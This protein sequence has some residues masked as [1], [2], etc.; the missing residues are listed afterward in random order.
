MQQLFEAI[1]GLLTHPDF[2]L[3]KSRKHQSDWTQSSS[4]WQKKITKTQII[5][6]EVK[7]AIKTL[8]PLAP[9][10]NPANLIG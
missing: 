5:T 7:E 6:P 1:T 9:L 2:G 4:R 10:H 8:I 3:S